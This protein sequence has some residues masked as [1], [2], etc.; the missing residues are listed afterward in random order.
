[1]IEK[2]RKKL[3]ISSCQL[4]LIIDYCQKQYPLEAC[5]LLSGKEEKTDK[6]YYITNTEASSTNYLMDPDEQLQALE[7]I[8]AENKELLAIFHS[9]PQSD[10]V[11][12]PRDI[13]LAYYPQALY[14]IIS[15]KKAR[16]QR[17]LFS[18]VKGSYHQEKLIIIETASEKRRE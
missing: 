5:G 4:E 7:E 14:L 9:H 16:P 15:L 1:M 18:I 6:I 17:A 11:P 12:S 10:P 13:R 3:I 8:R 2:K